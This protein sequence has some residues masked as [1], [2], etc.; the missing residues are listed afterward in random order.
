VS[1]TS[2]ASAAFC[3]GP[4]SADHRPVTEPPRT[5]QEPGPPGAIR[6]AP[7]VL[8][9]DFGA[10]AEQVGEVAAAADWLHVDVMDGH[11]VPNLSIGPPVVASLRRHSPLFFDCHLMM[12]NPGEYL[13]AFAQAGADGCTVHVEVGGTT[14][15]IAQMRRL[16]LRAGLALNPDTP[17]EAVAPF[18]DQVDL[19]LCMTVFPGFGGQSFMAEVLDKVSEV[20]RAVDAGALPVD[21]EVDGGIDATTGPRAARAGAN[22]FV[23][24]S[25][26]FGHERPWEAAEG[27]RRAVTA[28]SPGTL[29][30]N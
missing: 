6:I 18:L 30:K 22:V 16:G 2:T 15:L 14:E 5:R 27:I 4:G 13:E 26:V 19:V 10:L 8:S 3:A 25:A 20:R 21:I 1:P 23:A 24:G 11:F 28:P 7:S 12:T 29:D 17:F 9:A